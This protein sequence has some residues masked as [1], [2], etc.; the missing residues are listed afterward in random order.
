MTNCGDVT[1]LL[2][3]REGFSREKMENKQNSQGGVWLAYQWG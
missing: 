2:D 3:I 1:Q